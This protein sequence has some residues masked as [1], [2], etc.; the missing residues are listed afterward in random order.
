[1]CE[2]YPTGKEKRLL[3]ENLMKKGNKYSLRHAK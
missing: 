1:M 2:K 3:V